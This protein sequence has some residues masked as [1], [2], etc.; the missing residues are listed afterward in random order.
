LPRV[1]PHATRWLA[2]RWPSPRHHGSQTGGGGGPLRGLDEGERLGQE[3]VEVKTLGQ[4]MQ[5]LGF[6][7]NRLWVVQH[8][9]SQLE[10]LVPRVAPLFLS[11]HRPAP[12]RKILAEDELCALAA[13]YAE[14]SLHWSLALGPGT[15]EARLAA[16]KG[17]ARAHD[18]AVADPLSPAGLRRFGA[19]ALA[20]HPPPS[21]GSAYHRAE[22]REPPCQRCD[23]EHA[24][25][26]A[27]VARAERR[28]SSC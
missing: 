19:L 11:S 26:A 28:S 6:S 13:L 21:E 20:C 5:G 17:R 22:W 25:L 16:T 12:S 9:A 4:S 23:A 14:P 8:S 10:G 15:A 1:P 24:H 2:G 3:L 18:E 7:E 27:A